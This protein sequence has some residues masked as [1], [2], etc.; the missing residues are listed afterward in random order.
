MAHG[1]NTWYTE[2][3]THGPMP[4]STK[5]MAD[6]DWH[7]LASPPQRPE[8]QYH[9]GFR[10]KVDSGGGLLLKKLKKQKKQQATRL[11]DKYNC[12]GTYIARRGV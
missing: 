3:R 10:R 8:A 2:S 6:G 9:G 4:I 5:R 7:M 1:I 11:E 12:W